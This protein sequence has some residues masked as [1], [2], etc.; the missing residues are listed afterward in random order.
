VVPGEEFVWFFEGWVQKKLAVIV[1]S[2]FL[3][4]EFAR[5]FMASPVVTN[6]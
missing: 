3:F 4:I 2:V 1:A 5:K 6:L